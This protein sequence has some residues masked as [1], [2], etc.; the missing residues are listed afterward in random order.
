MVVVGYA[1]FYTGASNLFTGGQGYG[2]LESLL[3]KGE[4]NSGDPTSGANSGGIPNKDKG[5]NPLTQ[6]LPIG[7]GLNTLGKGL[8]ALGNGLDNLG[9]WLGL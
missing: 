5:T 1:I 3:N 2:F 8:N 6:P 4:A 7:P 9:G